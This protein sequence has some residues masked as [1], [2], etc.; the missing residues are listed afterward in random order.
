MS[1]EPVT[2]MVARRVARGRYRDFTTWLDE[3]RELACDYPGYLGSGVLAPP[4]GDDEYQIIFRFA[5][6]Q[7]MRAWEHSA[8]RRAWLGRGEGLYESPQ[9]YRATGIDSWFQ[10]AQGNTPPR[11]KQAVAIWL[12]FF[13]VSLMFQALF[14]HWLAGLPLVPRVLV[15]TLLLTPVMVFL[16]IPLSTRL[17]APWLHGEVT[18]MA[19]LARL[20]PHHRA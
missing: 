20:L 2:L 17:L 19:R 12:A 9:E 7:T 1:T 5:D 15:T 18:I 14:G 6:A 13:P 4:H 3:G 16:F 11:W 8:S 10:D